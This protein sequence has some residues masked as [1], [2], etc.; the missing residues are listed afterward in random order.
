MHSSST[1]PAGYQGAPWLPSARSGV[2]LVGAAIAGMPFVQQLWNV[3]ALAGLPKSIGPVSSPAIILIFCLLMGSA[4]LKRLGLT[5]LP[6]SQWLQRFVFIAACVA[7][8]GNK[9]IGATWVQSIAVLGMMSAGIIYMRGVDKVVRPTA[10]GL[11][12]FFPLALLVTVAILIV[13]QRFVNE[14]TRQA[15]VGAAGITNFLNVPFIVM[16]F[17]GLR[18]SLV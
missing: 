17:L 5:P 12:W 11:G 2:L 8:A 9:L 13:A 6:P 16:P 18:R 14:D 1:I 4:G 10:A 3:L 7:I 15:L